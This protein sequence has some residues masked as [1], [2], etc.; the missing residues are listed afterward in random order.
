[1]RISDCELRN[2]EQ[3]AK[4]H[5]LRDF[6][7]PGVWL[8]ARRGF[9]AGYLLP[10]VSRLERADCKG[11]RRTDTEERPATFLPRTLRPCDLCLCYPE[12]IMKAELD[13][14]SIFTHHVAALIGL[15]YRK[16]K[17]ILIQVGDGGLIPAYL[18]DLTI[19][20]GTL[21][22]VEHTT[23]AQQIKADTKPIRERQR[24]NE[25][26]WS[27]STRRIGLSRFKNTRGIADCDR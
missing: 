4:G 11:D 13:L 18:H 27:A 7:A 15:E 16:G 21:E 12:G 24:R 20:L 8:S 9:T 19:Q 3:R 5:S 23:S 2:M 10:D 25:F 26:L 17:R 6:A 1:M 14:N 22:P